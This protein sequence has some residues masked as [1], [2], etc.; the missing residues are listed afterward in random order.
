MAVARAV[1]ASTHNFAYDLLLY[2]AFAAVHPPE[3]SVE[4]VPR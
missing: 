3:E 4:T 2:R 1:F